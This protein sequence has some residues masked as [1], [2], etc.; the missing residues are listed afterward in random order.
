MPWRVPWRRDKHDAAIAKYVM[1]A[2]QLRCRM[3]RLEAPNAKRA[4]PF[5][6]DLL[7]QKHRLREEFNITDVVRMRVR[8]SKIF[9]VRGFYPQILKLG[10]KCLRSSPVRHAWI[11]RRLTIGHGG[12]RIGHPGVPKQPTLRMMHEVAV[13]GEVH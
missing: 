13:I 10:R 4:R 2:L 12:D 8:N 7:D 9:D 5:V 3:F 11:S 1:V 6:L